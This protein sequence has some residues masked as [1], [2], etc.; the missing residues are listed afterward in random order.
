MATMTAPAATCSPSSSTTPAHPAAVAAA[1]ARPGS[2]GGSRRPARGQSGPA[3][4]PPGGR[5]CWPE[6]PARPAPRRSARPGLSKKATRSGA[7]KRAKA[8]RRKKRDSL[9]AVGKGKV[10]QELVE[11]GRVGQVAA[12]LARDAQLGAQAAR[13]LQEQHLCALRQPPARRPSARLLHRQPPR[14]ALLCAID[15]PPDLDPVL[16]R[17]AVHASH[18]T[19]PAKET[20]R[21]AE[22]GR[23][24]ISRPSGGSS[25]QLP[26][27]AGR[28]PPVEPGQ[29][30]YQSQPAPARQPCG[31]QE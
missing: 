16:C 24:M 7:K 19:A 31:T 1:G 21:S 20:S 9:S 6:R 2:A 12:P 14:P 5:R 29:P 13:P 23:G 10:G 26:I 22:P 18:R 25:L 28:A 11:L 27:S 30:A 17:S 4:R 3:P 15:H 8:L